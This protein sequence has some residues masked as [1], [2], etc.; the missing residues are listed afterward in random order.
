MTE[1]RAQ[2][3]TVCPESHIYCLPFGTFGVGLDLIQVE[4]G[5]NQILG[6]TE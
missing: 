4:A 6:V 5:V 1:I 3:L 2:L